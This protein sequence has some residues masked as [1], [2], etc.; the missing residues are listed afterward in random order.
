MGIRYKVIL[1]DKMPA[2][3]WGETDTEARWIK[4]NSTKPKKTHASTFLHEI[5]HGILGASG[6]TYLL[7][8]KLEES[9]CVAVEHGLSSLMEFKK[10][11]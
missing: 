2:S 7:D 10:V 1:S 4:I 8:D 5:V 9:I 11:D 3:D 6:L